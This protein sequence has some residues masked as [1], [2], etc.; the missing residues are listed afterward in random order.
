MSFTAYELDLFANVDFE[1]GEL[2]GSDS[3]NE[4]LKKDAPRSHV[5]VPGNPQ[6][7]P[8]QVQPPTQPQGK[9]I[10]PQVS[11]FPMKQS[12]RYNPYVRPAQNFISRPTF[13]FRNY[14]DL[15]VQKIDVPVGPLAGRIKRFFLAF[16]DAMNNRKMRGTDARSLTKTINGAW[17]DMAIKKFEEASSLKDTMYN[18]VFNRVGINVFIHNFNPETNY[19]EE[20]KDWVEKNISLP[21]KNLEKLYNL[22][23]KYRR[24]IDEN[25]SAIKNSRELKAYLIAELR[26]ME[27]SSSFNEIETQSF[28]EVVTSSSIHRK[29]E[30][31]NKMRD[32]Y[33]NALG[34]SLE[35]E[36]A[37]TKILN[38]QW[39]AMQRFPEWDFFALNQIA[40]KNRV[41]AEREIYADME[42]PVLKENWDS[43]EDRVFFCESTDKKA[44][45]A[46]VTDMAIEYNSIISS[47]MHNDK[48][49]NFIRRY[50]EHARQMLGLHRFNEN[51]KRKGFRL[52][53]L[54]SLFEND[55]SRNMNI[56]FNEVK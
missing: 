42:S 52:S 14:N 50:G 11:K 53:R 49:F 41:D 45:A 32:F 17:E 12:A 28:W 46:F 7:P 18:I 9:S 15:K 56:W 33:Q 54:A 36:N 37:A 34:K 29:V 4:D 44:S 55:P 40:L 47:L 8:A 21:L 23:K 13:K 26:K 16:V 20:L 2:L 39:G 27:G 6:L 10:P 1:D 30:V 24:D 51:C 25:L 31:T 35:E 48:D 38:I 43:F 22:D 19:I 3:E 5:V